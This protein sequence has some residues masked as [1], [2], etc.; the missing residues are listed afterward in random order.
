[1]NLTILYGRLSKKPKEFETKAG[2]KGCKFSMATK[3]RRVKPNRD[4]WHTVIAY[5]GLADLCIKYLGPGSLVLIVGKTTKNTWIDAAGNWRETT[6]IKADVM[7]KIPTRFDL[8]EDTE[9][10]IFDGEAH[11]DE[12]MGVGPKE[13]GKE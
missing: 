7:E 10:N 5:G 1:M 3:D 2:K 6:E 9:E 12:P 13:G 8:I 11:D 4:T